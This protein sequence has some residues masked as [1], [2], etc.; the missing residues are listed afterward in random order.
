MKF[1]SMLFLTAG[2]LLVGCGGD[3]A[4]TS[5]GLGPQ[6]N[7]SAPQV[8]TDAQFTTTSAGL[9]IHDFVVGT[10]STAGTRDGVTVHY[11]GWLT[12]GTKFDS[13]VDRSEPFSFTIGAR[14]DILGWDQGVAGMRV[15]GKRQLEIPPNLAYGSSARGSIPANSTLVF[16][17]ELLK[18]E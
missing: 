11:T 13:S 16:E 15:G 18:V 3:D 9:K 2:L 8:V 1:R 4:I 6:L 17:I 10:G 5:L 7:T 14:E 12:D